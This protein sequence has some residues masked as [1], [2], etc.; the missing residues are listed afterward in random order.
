MRD[1][2]KKPPPPKKKAKEKPL[3][4]SAL[5]TH[6]NLINTFCECLAN[7]FLLKRGQS[8]REMKRQSEKRRA[9]VR[10]P[11]LDIMNEAQL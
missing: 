7:Y 9:Y 11:Y 8:G 2:L 5:M 10:K 3:A 4:V 1:S 6:L